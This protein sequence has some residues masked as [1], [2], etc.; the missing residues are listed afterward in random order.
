MTRE[1]VI[2]IR[3]DDYVYKTVKEIVEESKDLGMTKSE[4]GYV[5]LKAFFKVN[6]PP[7]DFE[8]IRELTIKM[9]KRLL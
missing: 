5:I 3:L 6:K 9:I 4:C 7:R 1:N 2:L 8:K